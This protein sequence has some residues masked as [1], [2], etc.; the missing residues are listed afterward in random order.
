M[1]AILDWFGPINAVEHQHETAPTT[2]LF[3]KAYPN[4]FN[5]QTTIQFSIPH[6]GPVNLSVYDASGNLVNRMLNGWQS[7]GSHEVA[8]DGTGL[9]S[10]I[11]F[12][13]LE[14]GAEQISGKIVL[15]K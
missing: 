11:Y 6:D 9:A 10:G 13:R 4:P 8:F 7:T 14:T 15:I 2:Y 12:Y 3:A 5:P 1:T